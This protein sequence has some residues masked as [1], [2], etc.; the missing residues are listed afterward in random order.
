MNEIMDDVLH[1][2]HAFP[3]APPVDALQTSA[4]CICFTAAAQ[5]LF[6]ARG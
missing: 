4:H 1:I 3:T 6:A 2:R 5:A